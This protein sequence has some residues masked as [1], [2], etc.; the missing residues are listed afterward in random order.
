MSLE[1][2]PNYE[3]GKGHNAFYPRKLSRFAEKKYSSSEIP[4]T[5]SK[6][7]KGWK[8]ACFCVPVCA[9]YW[10]YTVWSL[11]CVCVVSWY[12]AP[13][14]SSCSTVYSLLGFLPSSPL[15]LAPI[16]QSPVITASPHLGDS[17]Q[18]WAICRLGICRSGLLL[19]SSDLKRMIVGIIFGLFCL[20]CSSIASP[21]LCDSSGSEGAI[22]RLELWFWLSEWSNKRL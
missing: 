17:S 16:S 9:S 10:M 13:V 5:S 8:S 2:T 6:S 22:R 14:C 19:V 4:S 7:W 20:T 21:R 18:E 15:V 1:K 12:Y 11:L 3:F